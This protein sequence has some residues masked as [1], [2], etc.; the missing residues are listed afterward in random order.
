MVMAKYSY[1]II[2]PPIGV[3]RLGNSPTGFFI[4]PE[5]PR[6]GPNAQ[7]SFKDGAG[8]V[9]RQASRF[10]IYAYNDAGK[11]VDELTASGYLDDAA[12]ANVAFIDDRKALVSQADVMLAA[13]PPALV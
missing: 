1:C 10:R 13:Q 7:E 6:L 4:G 9:K 2:F 3:A 12:F 5:T 11:V 8:Q